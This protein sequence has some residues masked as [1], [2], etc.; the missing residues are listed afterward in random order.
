MHALKKAIERG[1]P[2]SSGT[3]QVRRQSNPTPNYQIGV[4]FVQG[5]D[6]LASPLSSE[7]IN[8]S[9]PE[10][11][12][13]DCLV[14][15]TSVLPERGFSQT[16]R[17]KTPFRS[18]LSSE[19]LA[20]QSVI[21]ANSKPSLSEEGIEYSFHAVL[22]QSLPVLFYPPHPQLFAAI[23]PIPQLFAILPIP[24]LAAILPIPQLFAAILPIPQLFAAILPIPQLVISVPF[25]LTLDITFC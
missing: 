23:L 3:I 24:Q 15:L 22:S 11:S 12:L 14:Q 4:P 7:P 18:H 5:N 6:Q 8:S 17:T 1:F 25:V 21:V 19:A 9:I 20:M 10:F 2:F 13:E 16:T